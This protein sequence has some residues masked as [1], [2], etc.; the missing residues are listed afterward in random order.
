MS[1]TQGQGPP[2]LPGS[3]RDSQP[4]PKHCWVRRGPP[5]SLPTSRSGSPPPGLLVERLR[6]PGSHPPTTQSLGTLPG[7][8]WSPRQPHPEL[9]IH[10][11]PGRS[12][13][14]PC[15]PLSALE[16]LPRRP[17]GLPGPHTSISPEPH[18]EVPSS[19]PES[20]SQRPLPVTGPPAPQGVSAE[21]RK[22]SRGPGSKGLE[23]ACLGLHSSSFLLR[24]PGSAGSSPGPRPPPLRTGVSSCHRLPPHCLNPFPP[25]PP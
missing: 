12:S 2:S 18:S 15:P 17:Q 4:A 20:S 21:E 19:A 16:P 25:G 5:P 7:E 3:I 24:L 6:N 23:P 22:G 13:A 1:L 9:R 10:C 11:A 14:A 8:P